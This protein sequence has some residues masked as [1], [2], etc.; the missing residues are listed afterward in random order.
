MFESSSPDSDVIQF[1]WCFYPTNNGVYTHHATEY[2]SFFF[3]VE[4]GMTHVYAS[5][6]ATLSRDFTYIAG[7]E[8]WGIVLKT[9]VFMPRLAKKEILNTNLELPVTDDA[10]VFNDERF[11]I[12]TYKTAEAFVDQ[13]ADNGTVLVNHV[14]AKALEGASRMAPRTIQRH[15]VQT[16]GITRQQMARIK[17]AREAF[18]LLQKGKTIHEVVALMDYVDQSHLT[19]SLRLLAGQTPAHILAAY[20]GKE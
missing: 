20:K 3:K 15:V 13:L 7:G 6:P 19:K 18:M 9:H 5:G 2:W 1:L 14:V 8:Y 4:H 16:T 17:R 12:P 10:F 11:V